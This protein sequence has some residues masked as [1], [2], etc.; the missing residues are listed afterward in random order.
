MKSIPLPILSRA[1]RWESC[2]MDSDGQ[3][4]RQEIMVN[5]EFANGLHVESINL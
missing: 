4:D 5:R 1:L 3:T 2:S